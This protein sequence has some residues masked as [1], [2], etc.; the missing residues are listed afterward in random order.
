MEREIKIIHN[1]IRCKVCG[2]ILESK[3]RHDWVCCKCWKESGGKKG[4]FVDGGKD[5]IR[6][7]GNPDT[8][9]LLCETRPYTDEEVDEYNNRQIELMEKYGWKLDLMEKK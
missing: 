6:T 2:E 3:H 1:R 4:V 5:Y 8:Y 9:E 7:G